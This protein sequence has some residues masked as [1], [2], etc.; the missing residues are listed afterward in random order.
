MDMS[1]ADLVLQQRDDICRLSEQIYMLHGMVE[2]LYDGETNPMAIALWGLERGRF[3]E[4]EKRMLLA[5]Q[6]KADKNAE[7]NGGAPSRLL[8][9]WSDEKYHGSEAWVWLVK[10]HMVTDQKLMKQAGL[11]DKTHNSVD[12]ETLSSIND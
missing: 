4:K 12:N 6:K 10:N 9:I 1:L 5:E 3:T 2:M 7:E 8:G 11:D